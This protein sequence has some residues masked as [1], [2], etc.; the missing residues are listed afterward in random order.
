MENTSSTESTEFQ[1]DLHQLPYREKLFEDINQ[2]L[3]VYYSMF[4]IISGTILNILSILT[5][6]RKSFKRS[7]T[8]VY[9]R[10]LAIV[11]LFVLYNGLSRHFISG[12]YHYN[13][14]HISD[15]FC[16]FNQWTTSFGPDISAWILVAVTGERVLSI[17]KPHSVRLMCTKFTARLTIL[18]IVAALMTTNLPLMLFYGHLQVNLFLLSGAKIL[19]CKK[20]RISKALCDVV[21]N[22]EPIMVTIILK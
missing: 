20:E 18:S 6:S 10:F 2:W 17:V 3:K 21:S 12:V 22:Y 7:T 15:A 14:R 1:T 16:K 11:D 5:L 8:S 9:L 13:V 4:L 19:S